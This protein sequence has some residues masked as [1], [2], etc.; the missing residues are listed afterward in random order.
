MG[1]TI[2]FHTQLSSDSRNHSTEGLKKEMT[3]HMG[4]TSTQEDFGKFRKEIAALTKENEDL[5]KH[6]LYLQND[7]DKL[8]ERLEEKDC[9]MEQKEICYDKT[10]NE[11]ETMLV[12]F[13]E[14]QE[15]NQGE[16]RNYDNR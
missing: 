10:K 4:N 13:Q 6:S 3:N 7:N 16:K 8:K 14:V 1:S 9:M 15:H 11:W 12:K 2:S 5:K